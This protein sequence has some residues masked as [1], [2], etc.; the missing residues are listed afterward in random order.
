M[1]IW[2]EFDTITDT[3]VLR[4]NSNF[5]HFKDLNLMQV[6]LIGVRKAT[7]LFEKHLEYTRTRVGVVLEAK[8]KKMKTK[9]HKN[10]FKSSECHVRKELSHTHSH[11]Q[12]ISSTGKVNPRWI[13]EG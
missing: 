5:Q 2:D 10:I 4:G 7:L 6:K 8:C 13:I 9:P 11:T 12:G 1:L 3:G